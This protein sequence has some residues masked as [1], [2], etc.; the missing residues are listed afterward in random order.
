MT[1]T[2]FY[3]VPGTGKTQAMADIVAAHSD[4]QLF[5]VVDIT[6][7]WSLS[8][9]NLRWRGN[10]PKGLVFG[11]A[12]YDEFFKHV[13]A[14][15][16]GGY[17]HGRVE[18]AEKFIAEN[19]HSGV[20]VFQFPFR[21][22]EVAEYAKA[23]GNSVFV[24]DEI[25]TVATYKDWDINPLKDFVHRGRHL[26]NRS[27]EMGTMGILGAARRPQSL[28]TDITSLADEIFVFRV[29]GKRTIDRLIGDSVIDSTKDLEVIKLPN[30]HYVKWTAQG[31]RSPG[32]VLDTGWKGE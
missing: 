30:L 8:E 17:K 26:P 3:G 18:S 7:D 5:F 29:N 12:E 22:W 13:R 10:V 16:E 21:P 19:D 23:V 1:T 27:G 2:L 14:S 32:R 6:N 24:S 4:E 11:Q 9:D 25:D 31:G 15:E 20:L 28:H